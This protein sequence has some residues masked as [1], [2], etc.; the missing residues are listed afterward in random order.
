MADDDIRQVAAYEQPPHVRFHDLGDGRWWFQLDRTHDSL[1]VYWCQPR[2]AWLGGS[3][4]LGGPVNVSHDP[5]AGL[6]EPGG[7]D[8]ALHI[9]TAHL[10]H[11]AG[12]RETT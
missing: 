2:N 9:A 6:A 3:G 7:Q 10:H 12:H 5:I 8:D 4:P 1:V 11:V